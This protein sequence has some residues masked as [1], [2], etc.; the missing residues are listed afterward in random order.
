MKKHFPPYLGIVCLGLVVFT[1][2]GWAWMSQP[3][4]ELPAESLLEHRLLDGEY[5]H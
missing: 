5:E 2:Y 3:V 1:A 4:P